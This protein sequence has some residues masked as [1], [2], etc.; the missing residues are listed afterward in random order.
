MQL[1]SN[2]FKNGA[3]LPKRFTCDGEN[4]SPALMWTSVPPNAES[5]AIICR[6]PDAP[7]RTWYH[8]AIFDLP[9]ATRE[10]AEGRSG[11]A[12]REAINDLGV[13]SYGGP[14]RW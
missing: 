1:R 5:F 11:V 12:A 3:T 13:R 4:I 6:D 8:W 10:L 14:G 7:A 9:P 2:A